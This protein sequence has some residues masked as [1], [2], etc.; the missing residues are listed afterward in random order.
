MVLGIWP[1]APCR[2][3]F[4]SLAAPRRDLLL[5]NRAADT[6]QRCRQG[7]RRTSDAVAL[8]KRP[9]TPAT[10]LPAVRRAHADPGVPD[11]LIVDLWIVDHNIQSQP[12]H[13]QSPDRRQ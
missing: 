1:P 7:N 11:L 5:S 10:L 3:S 13:R 12:L 6:S 8:M 4:N 9:R 2:S